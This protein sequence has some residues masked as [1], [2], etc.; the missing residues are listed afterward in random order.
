MQFKQDDEFNKIYNKTNNQLISMGYSELLK[1]NIE[2]EEEDEDED[3][4]KKHIV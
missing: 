3:D 4:I 1:K 2:E